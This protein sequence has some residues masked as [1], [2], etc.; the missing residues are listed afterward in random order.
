MA[1]R[2]LATGGERGGA[3][4]W[5]VGLLF[6][7][8]AAVATPSALVVGVFLAPAILLFVLDATPGKQIG[9]PIMTIAGATLVRPLSELWLA[10][11]VMAAALD[12][13]A[14]P[15]SVAPA[16]GLQAAGWLA[17]EAA[18]ALIRLGFEGAARRRSAALRRA[19]ARIEA[20]WGIPPV[21]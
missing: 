9:W 15:R 6:G 5:F 21:E 4:N 19:R 3:T 14:D 10:G 1:T 7:A 18:P 2:K 13:A 12:I 11:H 20:E 8:A 16:W 17:I